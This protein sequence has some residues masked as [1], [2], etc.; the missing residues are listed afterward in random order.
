MPAHLEK[1]NRAVEWLAR[2]PEFQEKIRCL[3]TEVNHS[4]E[5]F[6]WS[7]VDLDSLPVTLPEHIR[8]GWIF[9][10][11]KNVGS[12]CHYHPNSVQHMVVL[13]GQG[14]SQVASL[15]KQMHRFQ[16]PGHSLE[17]IWYVIDENTPHEFF[18]EAEHMVV[19]SFHTCEA[20]EL[21][22]IS[23]ESGGK[24]WYEGEV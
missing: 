3:E 18:P 22:E 2:Q 24:R 14:R 15:S 16:E 20:N 21:E 9:V 12:G 19:V 17:E 4:Q 11:K 23:C 6:V 10:L 8:S 5:S 1:L 7:V 13:K